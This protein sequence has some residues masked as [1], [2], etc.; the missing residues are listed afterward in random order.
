MS[1]KQHNQSSKQQKW[2]QS[3]QTSTQSQQQ[4][5]TPQTP[6]TPQQQFPIQSFQTQSQQ[7]NSPRVDAQKRAE[8]QFF[9][10]MP[11]INSVEGDLMKLLNEFTNTSLQKYGTDEV[12][13]KLFKKMDAIREKQEKIARK[14]F[15]QETILADS[16]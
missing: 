13:E 8:H 16:K 12:H 14:H 2:Q 10:K 1:F 15:E 4:Q 6:Q 9:N 3:P 5:P 7:V 11:D